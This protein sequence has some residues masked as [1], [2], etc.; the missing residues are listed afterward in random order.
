[1]NAAIQE[2]DPER[3]GWD[4]DGGMGDEDWS[5][6]LAEIREGS[7]TPFLGSGA[8][9][10]LLPTGG[11]LARML[12]RRYQLEVEPDAPLPRVAQNVALLGRDNA[13]RRFI[14]E[15][16]EA[17]G[18]PNFG[19]PTQLHR[20]LAELP[21]SIYVTTNYDSFMSLALQSVDKT[22]I[23]ELCRWF[24][25]GWDEPDSGA[26]LSRAAE[27]NVATPLVYHLHGA[28]SKFASMVLSE[29]DYL[30][31]LT[32]TSVRKSLVPSSVQSSFAEKTLLFLGYSLED[33][34]FKVLL[35]RIS[36]TIRRFD[37]PHL[38]VQLS[39]NSVPVTSAD[40]QRVKIRVAYVRKLL[41]ENA[42]IYWGSCE[43]FA[44]ELADRW[45]RFQKA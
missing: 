43:R 23:V 22:P 30:D 31:F 28:F 18:Q 5:D 4:G 6:L 42:R 35:R 19:L 25:V 41:G 11:E 29:D 7:C 2:P 36:A 32:V 34:T 20:V 39:H 45:N 12:V 37:K 17:R 13:M 14:K 21:L 44:T 38:T 1:M 16:C 8:S 26:Q 24:C 3:G 15:E 40:R 27:A 9:T 33:M 10:P